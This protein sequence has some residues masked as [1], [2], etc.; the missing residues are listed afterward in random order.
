LTCPYCGYPLRENENLCWNCGA[1]VPQAAWPAQQQYQLPQ[2][3]QQYQ[4]LQQQTWW[5]APSV[6]QQ[7]QYQQAQTGY[8]PPPQAPQTTPITPS[9]AMPSNYW[10]AE[11][12][13]PASPQPAQYVP[14][15]QDNSWQPPQN[16]PTPE[17]PTN[18]APPTLTRTPALVFPYAPVL[19]PSDRVGIKVLAKQQIQGKIGA[20][21]VC[22]LLMGVILG[23]ASL[24]LGAGVLLMPSFMISFAM[25]YL[26]LIDGVTPEPSDVFKG[27]K[28]F[29]KALWLFIV[30][31]FFTMCWALLLFVPGIIKGI[32]Y[33]LS[34]YILAENPTMTAREA[35][36][37]SKRLTNGH[38][39]EMFV[40]Q[41]SFFG[42]MW[43]MPFTLGLLA[44]WLMPYRSATMANYYRAL[45]DEK[46]MA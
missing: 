30:Q 43:L 44:I 31:G 36:A 5:G 1:Y 2:Q 45:K 17:P 37:E 14:P 28:L 7:Y 22:T 42:W 38:I 8:N 18:S 40:L 11:P 4:A 6:Q 26:N 27:L 20:L 33:S 21:F 24:L 23:P 13:A 19:A 32:S 25:I 29:G 12:G 39:G 35:I 34:L 46:T 16:K 10:Q 9:Y 3:Q 15:Q 41:L